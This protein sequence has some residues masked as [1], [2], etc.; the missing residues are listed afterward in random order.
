M[1]RQPFAFKWIRLK[2]LLEKI[3]QRVRQRSRMTEIIFNSGDGVF[4]VI[5]FLPEEGP[6]PCHAAYR[7]GLGGNANCVTDLDWQA[8]FNARDGFRLPAVDLN[9]FL[10]TFRS[11]VVIYG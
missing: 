9:P 11:G 8:N 4:P 1:D 10:R 5:V 2:S 3:D 6:Y 7:A